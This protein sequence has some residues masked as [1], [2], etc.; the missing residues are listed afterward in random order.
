V[1]EKAK[2]KEKEKEEEEEEESAS[3]IGEVLSRLKNKKDKL[4]KTR[5][6]NSCHTS[7]KAFNC[8]QVVPCISHHPTSSP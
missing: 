6:L 7:S 8:C 3:S 4:G 5:L 1:V 2:V